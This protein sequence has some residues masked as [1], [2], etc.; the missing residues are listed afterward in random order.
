MTDL[1]KDFR[2][3]V[4]PIAPATHDDIMRELRNVRDR[5]DEADKSSAL[6]LA[7]VEGLTTPI[8]RLEGLI[9]ARGDD[10]KAILDQV[11]DNAR[12]INGASE[13][14]DELLDWRDRVAAISNKRQMRGLAR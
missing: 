2:D 10:Y 8:T 1:K 5:Q 6:R 9:I 7:A 13:K 12:A 3:F 11:A 14:V 4:D